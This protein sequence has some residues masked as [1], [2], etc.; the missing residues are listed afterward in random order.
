MI[1][2]NLQSIGEPAYR[3]PVWWGPALHAKQK[4]Q[5]TEKKKKTT[6]ERSLNSAE[7]E[8]SGCSRVINHHDTTTE[9]EFKGCSGVVHGCSKTTP[10]IDIDVDGPRSPKS[11]G[12]VHMSQR[13]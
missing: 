9:G 2:D 12:A 3:V 6:Q 5:A 4:T 10:K 13:D 11:L 1:V 8:N 7:K